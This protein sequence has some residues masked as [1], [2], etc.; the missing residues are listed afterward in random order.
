MGSTA[1]V[2]ADLDTALIEREHARLFPAAAPAP[3]AAVMAVALAALSQQRAEAAA[4]PGL[5]PWQRGGNWRLNS[6]AEQRLVFQT[7]G[8][9]RAV[10]ARGT[11]GN[12]ELSLG[13]SQAQAPLPAQPQAGFAFTLD[14][15]RLQAQV[16]SERWRYDVFL[17]GAHFSLELVDPLAHVG[18]E[19][20]AEGGIRALMPGRVV[21]LLAE[22]GARVGKGQPL[23]ILEAMKMEHTLSAP[24]DGVCEGF[25]VAVGDQVAEGA[26]LVK[27]KAS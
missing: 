17:Q 23:L 19:A 20:T 22:P 3:D 24:A 21:A 9:E 11:A 6:Q 16:I 8:V 26:D 10:L 2:T 18:E 4:G 27:F 15:R 13:D 25:N 1:F 12:F 7:Q 5:A 14:G